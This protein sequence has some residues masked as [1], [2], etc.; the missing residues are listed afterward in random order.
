MTDFVDPIV[1]SQITGAKDLL[2][3]EVARATP[4]VDIIEAY[5]GSLP[6]PLIQEAPIDG[7]Q[8]A[9]KDGDW[10]VVT[11]GEGVAVWGGITGDL[12]DQVDLQAALDSKT[13]DSTLATVAKSGSYS[14]LTGK[15]SIIPEAPIDT[16][17]YVRS[18]AGWEEVVVE[19]PDSPTLTGTITHT[20]LSGSKSEQRAPDDDNVEYVVRNVFND[21]THQ[22]KSDDGGVWHSVGV[23][24]YK[25][26]ATIDEVPTGGTA[27]WGSIDGTLANQTDLQTALN[28]KANSGDLATVATSGS[29]TDLTNKPTITSPTLNGTT[30]ANSNIVFDAAD[31]NVDFNPLAGGSFTITSLGGGVEEAPNDGQQYARQSQAWAVVAGG[32]GGG[33]SGIDY[34]TPR[35]VQTLSQ[36][37]NGTVSVTPSAVVAGGRLLVNMDAVDAG[38]TNIKVLVDNPNV[39]SLALGDHFEIEITNIPRLS[40]SIG[41]Q[42]SSA[43]G[44]ALGT[45]LGR[46]GLTVSNTAGT[47]PTAQSRMTIEAV[48]VDHEVQGRAWFWKDVTVRQEAQF[49]SK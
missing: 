15:P 47:V 31:F 34:T 23:N 14:D 33:A 25:R 4:A 41:V 21:I 2:V 30:I 8:Y 7:E 36:F 42:F 46:T 27:T 29:Y 5:A 32:T 11:G 38:T 49:Y 22:V 1:I 9:R 40:G 16:K 24:N 18:D 17:Q 6:D 26:L 35:V 45:I 28:L 12:A 37:A 39:Y 10:T 13:T 19:I 3:A 44:N 43:G 48:V 20:G